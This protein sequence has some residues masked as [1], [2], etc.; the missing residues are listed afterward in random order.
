MN[1]T[2]SQLDAALARLGIDAG[3]VRNRVR[4]EIAQRRASEPGYCKS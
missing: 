2:V 4:A 1:I 3:T